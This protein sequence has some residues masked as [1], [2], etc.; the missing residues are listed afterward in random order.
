MCVLYVK[1]CI[2]YIYIYIYTPWT[3]RCTVEN[4]GRAVAGIAHHAYVEC[5]A[6]THLQYPKQLTSTSYKTRVKISR[7]GLLR[8]LTPCALPSSNASKA[9]AS[10]ASKQEQAHTSLELQRKSRPQ[11]P[12]PR[13]RSR[14]APRSRPTGHRPQVST[15]HRPLWRACALCTAVGPCGLWFQSLRLATAESGSLELPDQGQRI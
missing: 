3:V 5:R 11:A 10:S 6:A 9:A 14:A 8:T 15:G 13:R 7:V 12:G 2:G 1:R 4:S